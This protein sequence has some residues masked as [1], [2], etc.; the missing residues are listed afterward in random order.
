M[1]WSFKIGKLF[2]IPI[3]VHLT[4]L[5]LLFFIGISGSKQGGSEGAILG[6]IVIIFIFICVILHEVGHSLVAI[7]YGIKVN[8]IILLPIGGVSRMEEIPEDPK[9]EIT[10]SVVGPLVSFGLAI[11]FFVLSEVTHQGIGFK[12][13]NIYSRNVVASLFWINLVLGVFN[14]I[15]AFPMDGGRVLRGILAIRMESL[16]ATKIAVGIGQGFAILLFFFGIFFNWWM[17]L[18][19]IFIYLG[20]EGEE[21]MVAVKNSLGKSPVKLAMLTDVHTVSPQ[22]TVGQVLERICHSFQQDFP[23]EEGGEVVG[24]LTRETI[25]SAL[26]KHEKTTLVKDIMQKDFVYTTADASL[27]EIYKTMTAHRLYVMP[28]MKGK[29]LR[30]MIN[31][32]QIGKYHMICQEER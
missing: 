18:I 3:R 5:L 7:H 30:G 23:V 17:A 6:M 9:Q 11:L 16:K 19:A 26:H 21:R 13:I 10:I 29:K 24:I 32:E 28:V 8:D 22:E 20:A 27:S 31:L 25:F 15:P 12:Q 1:K 2:G 14:L 4:F